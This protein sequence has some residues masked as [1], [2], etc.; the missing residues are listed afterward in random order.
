MRKQAVEVQANCPKCSTILTTEESFTISLAKD[1][2]A[3]YLAF[4]V[5]RT[6]PSNS[7]LAYKLK[8]TVKRYFVDGSILY[9]KGFNGEP[10]RCLG[11]TESHQV[12]Q[13]IHAGECGEH[14]GMKK[15]HRQLLSFG[16][17]WPTM[18]RDAH[19]FVKKCHTCQIHANLSHKPPTLL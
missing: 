12:M 6:L 8:K 14:Q 16:Y 9:R 18:K 7:K 13:E 10:L 17:Y 1:W 5:E 2:R 3:P 15:L 4:F 11:N 19:D